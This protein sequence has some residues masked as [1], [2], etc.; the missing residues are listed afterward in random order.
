VCCV[1]VVP[2]TAVVGTDLEV[3]NGS[4]YSVPESRPTPGNPQVKLEFIADAV[5][6]HQNHDF[7]YSQQ[8]N[9]KMCK[10]KNVNE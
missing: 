7:V 4:L 9:E 3:G 1:A 5:V 6:F 10:H 8:K 2:Y